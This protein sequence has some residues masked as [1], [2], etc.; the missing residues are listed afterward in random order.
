MSSTS[1]VV[2]LC[3]FCVLFFIASTTAESRN[4]RPI[5]GILAQETSVP[6]HQALGK[7][8]I[9]ASYVK[10]LESAGAR[11]VPIRINL[12]EI[13]YEKLFKSINGVLFPGGGVNLT[14]SGY[15]RSASFFYKLAIKA[16][17]EG[18]YFPIWATCLGFEELTYLTSGKLLLS[19]TN[20]TNVTLPLNFQKDANSSRLFKDFPEDLLQALATEPLTENSHRWS[21]S[22]EKFKKNKKLQQFYSILTTNKDENLEFISTFEAYKYPIYGTQWHPEKNP[23]EWEKPVIPHSPT[24]VKATFYVADFFVNEARKNFHHFTTEVEES[25]A[26]IYNYSPVY[27]AG[28]SIYEQ[29]YFFS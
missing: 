7:S 1:S 8:Y 9:A 13:E 29:M 4:D 14:S 6:S 5:I 19:A 12:P 22:V 24:A 10:F 16:N 3:I 23:Y 18:D 28:I 27:T 11:V 17:D 2:T 25:K 21:L 20:T 26:L 15:A